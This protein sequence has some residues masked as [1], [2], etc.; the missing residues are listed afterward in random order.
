MQE[1]ELSPSTQEMGMDMQPTAEMVDKVADEFIKEEAEFVADKKN[2]RH[3]KSNLKK[4]I[5]VISLAAAAFAMS[6]IGARA[7]DFKVTRA[8]SAYSDNEI[9]EKSKGLEEQQ[10]QDRE[11]FTRER[12]IALEAR[13]KEIGADVDLRVP[14]GKHLRCPCEQW[15]VFDKD[16][17]ELGFIA[18]DGIFFQDDFEPAVRM[19][20]E[21]AEADKVSIG[22]SVDDEAQD[23]VKSLGISLKGN[24]LELPS[25]SYDLTPDTEDVRIRE[26][27]DGG[28][29]IRV[30]NKDKSADFMSVGSD[31]QVD[32]VIHMPNAPW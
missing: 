18:S 20:V 6:E 27:G 16:G 7:S 1:N 22:L 26:S 31:G 29:F 8:E 10:M 23:E 14:E 30:L 9:R 15:S 21:Q 12:E 17:K 11:A 25:Q 13:S 24:V 19:V 4:A 28:V 3:G 32:Q 5:R 2:D